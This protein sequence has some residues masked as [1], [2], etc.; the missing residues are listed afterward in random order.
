MR[1]SLKSLEL[2][3]TI[4]EQKSI[5]RAARASNIALAAASRRLTLLE[6]EAG[7]R[8]FNRSNSGAELTPAGMS[9]LSSVR[10]ILQQIEELKVLLMDYGKGV[11]GVVRVYANTSALLQHVPADLGT[12][13]ALFPDIKIHLQERWS[14][15]II[16]AVRDGTA[17][18]GITMESPEATGLTL[19]EYRTDHLAAVTPRSQALPRRIAFAKLLDFDL[20]T[21]ES[22]TTML[23]LLSHKAADEKR[24]LRL[25][26]QVK[27]FEAVCRMVQA[28]LGIGILPQGAVREMVKGMNLKL[29]PFTDKWANRTMYICV[30]D[31]GDLSLVAWQLVEHLRGK[32]TTGR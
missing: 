9:A 22:S 13:A 27:S 7:I 28:G 12:F 23:R 10:R 16:Q 29:V 4:A 30:R 6:Q 26:V 15:D 32:K 18:V 11:K 19:Y 1:I 2:F 21:L 24:P 8:L 20:V 5:T 25:R 3:S 17:D 31:P 14:S